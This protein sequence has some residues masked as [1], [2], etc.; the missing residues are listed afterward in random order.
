MIFRR[1]IRLSVET[2]FFSLASLQIRTVDGFMCEA[3][4]GNPGPG[5]NKDVANLQVLIA[6]HPH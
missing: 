1:R 3:D 4:H 6:L 2:I 5:D